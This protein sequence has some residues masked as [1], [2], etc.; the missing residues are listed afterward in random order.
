MTLDFRGGMGVWNDL[1]K[2]QCSEKTA[3]NFVK[4]SKYIF[5][6]KLFRQIAEEQK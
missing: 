1:Q 3:K 5:V 6:R 4:S 2:S